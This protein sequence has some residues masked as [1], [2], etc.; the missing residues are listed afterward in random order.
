[1]SENIGEIKFFLPQEGEIL[2]VYLPV[3]S[4][5]QMVKVNKEITL[6]Y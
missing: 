3:R 4:E 2:T 6:H 1:M 5:M